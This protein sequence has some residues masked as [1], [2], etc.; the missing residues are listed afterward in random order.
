[1]KASE[2]FMIG[3]LIGVWLETIPYERM[4][5]PVKMRCFF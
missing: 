3:V 2:R 5:Y 1:M 4:Y